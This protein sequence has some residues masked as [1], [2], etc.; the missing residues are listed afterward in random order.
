MRRINDLASPNG[1]DGLIIDDFPALP[2]F[3]ESIKY[4][5]F[6]VVLFT[7]LQQENFDL[8]FNN[9]LYQLKLKVPPKIESIHKIDRSH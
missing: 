7:S 9:S 5:L 3:C 4:G 2:T 6:L 1:L 8:R